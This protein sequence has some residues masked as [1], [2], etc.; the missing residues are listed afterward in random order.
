[1]FRLFIA[2]YPIL[3][4]CNILTWRL[5]PQ[6]LVFLDPEFAHSNNCSEPE[7]LPLS[8]HHFPEPP[9]PRGTSHCRHT[10]IAASVCATT[11][12]DGGGIIWTPTFLCPFSLVSRCTTM[13]SICRR[14]YIVLSMKAMMVIDCLRSLLYSSLLLLRD[15]MRLGL[16]G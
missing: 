7:H 3:D 12:P 15:L 16:D 9:R 11:A 8:L 2:C 13:Q 14:L 10:V 4:V 5:V 1:M 6:C